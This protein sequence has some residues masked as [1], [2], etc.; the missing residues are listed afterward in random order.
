MVIRAT[1]DLEE[2]EELTLAYA[3]VAG[4]SFATRQLRLKKY[5]MSCDC[6]L[7][8]ADRKDGVEAC[9]RRQVLIPQFGDN[10]LYEMTLAQ[11]RAFLC[12][13]EGTYAASRGII[14][15]E[16]ARIRHHMAIMNET[17]ARE[18]SNPS[19]RAQSIALNMAVLEAYGVTVQDKSIWGPISSNET[20]PVATRTSAAITEAGAYC[21][22]VSMANSYAF[23]QMG[24]FERAERWFR[25][26]LWL[27]DIFAGGGR[28]L[29]DIVHEALLD[30]MPGLSDFVAQI[31]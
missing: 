19:Y 21:I 5:M 29:F 3:D 8:D 18:Q 12:E 30:H 27:H 13:V 10:R 9:R 25:A 26:G 28:K 31:T 1:R 14:R 2:G 15:P 4:H 17:I 11:V 23:V 6:L 7:C 22:Q 24:D 20:L 16:S